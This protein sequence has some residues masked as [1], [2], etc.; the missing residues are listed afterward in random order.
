M[1]LKQKLN[2]VTELEKKL[3]QQNKELASFLPGEVKKIRYNLNMSQ[4]EF[5]RLLGVTQVYISRI[6]L[7][8]AMPSFDLLNRI[9][10]LEN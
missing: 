1:Q 8:A 4:E 2:T 10:N 9:A 3:Q 6:E 7:G 5:A